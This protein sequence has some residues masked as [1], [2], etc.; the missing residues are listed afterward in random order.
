MV[1]SNPILQI[2]SMIDSLER[3]D[4]Q[5]EET[6]FKVKPKIVK[7]VA[8]KQTCLSCCWWR[9]C[10]CRE[11]FYITVAEEAI[12]D[13]TV[14]KTTAAEEITLKQYFAKFVKNVMKRQKQ[15]RI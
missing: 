15:A 13:G 4:E 9:N 6:N 5:K 1:I 8:N 14:E 12:D 7:I 11:P 2:D 3:V 10:Q